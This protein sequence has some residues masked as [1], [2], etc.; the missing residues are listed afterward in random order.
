MPRLSR[1][2]QSKQGSTT[3]LDTKSLSTVMDSGDSAPQ[4]SAVGDAKKQPA[5]AAPHIN[6]VDAKKLPAAA[7]PK[8]QKA[9]ESSTATSKH[10]DIAPKS[11]VVPEPQVLGTLRVSAVG[12]KTMV[13]SDSLSN[14]QPVQK[15]RK[16][17]HDRDVQLKGSAVGDPRK[18]VRLVAAEGNGSK[19]DSQTRRSE[20]TAEPVLASAKLRGRSNTENFGNSSATEPDQHVSN[21]TLAVGS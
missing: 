3:T 10:S 20:D 21:M 17:G 2:P 5:A 18:R 12:D 14:P 16:E 8:T 11:A 9:P 7:S 15:R 6:K 19:P 4:V 13:A 1:R